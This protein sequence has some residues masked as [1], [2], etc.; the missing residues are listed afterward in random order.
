MT[1]EPVTK[2]EKCGCGYEKTEHA[3]KYGE[4]LTI[5]Y[6]SGCMFKEHNVKEKA[7][8]SAA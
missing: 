5:R 3:D 2:E 6:G 8:G 7:H 1:E 4:T